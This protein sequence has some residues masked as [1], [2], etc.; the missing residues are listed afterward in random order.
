MVCL[1]I[2]KINYVEY[3]SN[4]A[5]WNWLV[6]TLAFEKNEGRSDLY[7]KAKL[8]FWLKVL[9]Y[10]KMHKLLTLWTSGLDSTNV[11]EANLKP[12]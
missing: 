12:R 11:L 10:Y 9:V 7:C 1:S 4:K 6:G 2:P 8:D 3:G 5:K